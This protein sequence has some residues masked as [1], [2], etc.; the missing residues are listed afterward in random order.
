MMHAERSA[1]TLLLCILA[2]LAACGVPPRPASTAV[3]AS[4]ADLESANP[5]VTVHPMSR[6]VQRH[7]L[8]VTLVRL[9]STL[10]PVPYYA[11]SWEW[12]T[13]QKVLTFHL[14]RELKW[15]D[16]VPTSAADAKFTF[17][18][19]GNKLL[20]APRAAD[21]AAVTNVEAPD[22]STLRFTFNAPQPA[23]PVLFAELPLVPAHLLDT[24][25]LPRWRAH[26]FSTNPV[27]NGP[28]QFAERVAGRRWRFIRNENFPASMGGPPALQ[29]FVVAV[30]DEAAT[31][32]AGLVSGELDMAGISPSMA[33][34]VTG[35]STLQLE[36]PPALFSTVMAFNTTRAPFDNP[37]VRQAIA[38]SVDRQR[39]VDAAV[40]GFGTPAG[41]VIPPG[42]PMYAKRAP[43]TDTARA[44]SLLDLAG[45][46][47]DAKGN[48]SRG[49][50]PL[51]IN[52]ITVGSGD[53]AA[54]QLIQAD[55]RVR[56][57]TLSVQVRELATFLAVVR[58]RKKEFDAA[59]VGIPGD[60][61]L[62][63]VVAMFQ[64]TQ[65]GG[66]LDYT[67]FH[68]AA[69][70]SALMYA[71]VAPAGAAA[72]GAWQIV[73]S[74]LRVGNPAV[75][76]YHSRGVQGR[77]RKLHNVIMDL[78]G[79]LTSITRWVRHDGPVKPGVNPSH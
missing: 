50:V 40:A 24:V 28:F 68:T 54:E 35:D 12:D 53:M 19:L 36:T 52:L 44:D 30:V 20:G 32:F 21:V 41:G 64:S 49:G 29:Q 76:I 22:D 17:E 33:K 37:L 73:D 11:R 46:P 43:V 7:A 3:I 72:L 56:G 63:Q 74:L 58:A 75:W 47:R 67:G 26:E 77:S 59:Y 31:K 18:S 70:D 25:P 6:Q 16:G 65:S 71:R 34:L 4:G 62:G 14:H 45:W 48:R 61:G 2:V 55:L 15:H 42:V 23:L 69:L 5:L 39:V 1:S 8:F 66:A 9:D 57:I 78:R 51:H 13:E 79:E 38:L 60:L 10:R 27:G